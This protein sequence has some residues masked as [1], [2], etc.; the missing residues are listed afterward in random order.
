MAEAAQN[1]ARPIAPKAPDGALAP[2]GGGGSPDRAPSAV[3]A[4]QA[5]G[6]FSI[7]KPGQGY[8]TRLITCIG[9]AVVLMLVAYWSYTHGRIFLTELLTSE[10]RPVEAARKLAQQVA[11]GLAVVIYLGGAAIVWKIVNSPRGAEFLITTDSEMKKVNWA[12]WKEVVGSTRVVILFIFFVGTF[13]FLSDIV[14][15][16][17][18]HVIKVLKASPFG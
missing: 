9:A 7:Y 18:F 4:A 8:W 1:Q 5:G 13:L 6:F 10:T 15:S 17:F 12:T 16:W 11:L 3:P 2:A 14:F